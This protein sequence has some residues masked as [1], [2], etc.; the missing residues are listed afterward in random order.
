[1][2]AESVFE[3]QLAQ[4]TSRWTSPPV[5]EGLKA[6]AKELGLWNMFLSKQSEGA[7]Y[8]NLEYALMAEYLGRSKLGPEV[9]S[10]S[11]YPLG[12]HA[13][14]LGNKQLGPGY[15]QHGD[16][17]KVWDCGTEAP[18]APAAIEWRNSIGLRDDRARCSLK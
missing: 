15:R 2:P 1:M 17:C 3:A 10:G 8:T 11:L 5:L 14:N 12:Q 6:R 18:L 16:H 7:G 13:D 9:G 4:E